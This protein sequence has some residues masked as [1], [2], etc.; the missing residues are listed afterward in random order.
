MGDHQRLP[1]KFVWR[2]H[3]SS[4][5]KKADA[6]YS[7][8]LGWRVEPFETGDSTY[9]LIL[10]GESFDT[11]IGGYTR[12]KS[13]LHRSHW[14]SYVSVD[15]VDATVEAVTANGGRVVEAPADVPDVGRQARI[16]DPQGAQLCLFRDAKADPPDP[17]MTG[18]MPPL[19]DYR[20]W[21]WN[22]LHTTEPN[23]AL[24][25]YEKV[26]G[27]S[28]R[29]VNMG[30]A[31]TYY[32]L[33]KDGVDRAGVTAHLSR[34]PHWLPYAAVENATAIIAHARELGATIVADATDIPGVGRIGVLQDP[35]GA[36][37]AVLQP[38]TTASQAGN[39]DRMT[40]AG[41]A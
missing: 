30:K 15:D 27:Y 4:D 10:S 16:A 6:F 32:I 9:D 20:R 13:D 21:V 8:L 22:E 2:E 37:L 39:S 38:R 12:I 36:M 24:A 5:A 1:G 33:A 34:A 26:I 35:T 23:T 41:K 18:G 3:V 14:I 29:T 31:G 25:F 19:T 40:V 17:P 11:M 7:A 28:H